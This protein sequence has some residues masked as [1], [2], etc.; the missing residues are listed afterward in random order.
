MG[1]LLV[2]VNA[3]AEHK[4]HNTVTLPWAGVGRDAVWS[5]IFYRYRLIFR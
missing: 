2:C 1:A 3:I 4:Q 5:A